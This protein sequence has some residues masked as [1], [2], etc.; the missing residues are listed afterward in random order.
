MFPRASVNT[1]VYIQA[2][3]WLQ[4]QQ[5]IKLDRQK[6]NSYSIRERFLG[7]QP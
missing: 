3:E 6:G 1:G 4:D 2:V 5:N 7:D